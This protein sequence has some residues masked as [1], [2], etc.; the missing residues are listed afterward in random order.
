MGCSIGSMLSAD[1]QQES[2]ERKLELP[3]MEGT[4][5]A[6]ILWYIYTGT[7]L[8]WDIVDKAPDDIIDPS[9]LESF[10]PNLDEWAGPQFS[11]LPCAKLIIAAD[12][13]MLERLVPLLFKRLKT[14]YLTTIG[15]GGENSVF[16]IGSS[17]YKES[18]LMLWGRD[19]AVF[20]RMEGL[21]AWMTVLSLQ[22][23]AMFASL[24]FLFD[25]VLGYALAL[26]RELHL[27]NSQ[28]PCSFCKVHRKGIKA[29]LLIQHYPSGDYELIHCY[30]GFRGFCCRSCNIRGEVHH[31]NLVL[32]TVCADTCER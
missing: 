10:I 31:R 15:K 14:N 13:L 19:T 20:R 29:T 28:P 8:E 21:I 30:C 27:V 26:F 7:L 17:D 6:I 5:I 4:V 22:K 23:S 11:L 2:T 32:C 25:G 24:N 9:I 3:D 16:V 1:S 12:R 18:M